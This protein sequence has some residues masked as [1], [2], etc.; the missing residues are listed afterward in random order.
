[1]SYEECYRVL[2]VACS[3]DAAEVTAAYRRLAKRLHPDVSHSRESQRRF[4]Q[5]AHAYAMLREQLRPRRQHSHQACCPYCGK[6]TD[7]YQ[8]H[9]GLTGCAD[10]LLG[11]TYRS[12][13]LPLPV[14]VCAKHLSVLVLYVVSILYLVLYLRADDWSYALV[15][16]LAALTGITVL[17]RQVLSLARSSDV[18]RPAHRGHL[19]QRPTG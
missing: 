7:L 15:S 18:L 19:S 8:A 13:F 2:G 14:V 16:L 6:H 12:H 9:A 10:C 1:M 3:A 4:V 17:A 5:A 11:R